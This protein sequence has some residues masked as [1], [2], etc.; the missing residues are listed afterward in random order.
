M[1]S[2]FIKNQIVNMDTAKVFCCCSDKV[3]IYSF[4]FSLIMVYLG[5]VFKI[6]KKTKHFE[7]LVIVYASF[8]TK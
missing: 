3:I 5:S 4:F 1:H 7:A 2:F 6:T 8:G